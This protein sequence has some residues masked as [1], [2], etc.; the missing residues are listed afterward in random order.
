MPKGL[1]RGFMQHAPVPSLTLA[2][3]PLP[4]AAVLLTV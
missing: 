1:K 3:R 2:M 4:A